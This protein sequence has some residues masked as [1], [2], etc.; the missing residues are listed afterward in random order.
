MINVLYISH[1]SADVLGSS[2]SLF[3]MITSLYGKVNPIVV[4]PQKGPAFDFF[5]QKQICT[6]IVPYP[7]DITDKHGCKRYISFLPRLLKD[8]ILYREGI[9]KIIKI[10]K[11]NNIDIIHSNSSTIDVGYYVSEKTGKPHVWHLR[12][13]QDLDFGFQPVYGWNRLIKFIKKASATICITTAIQKHFHLEGHQNSFQI[14]NAVRSSKKIPIVNEKEKYFMCCGK[15]TKAKG[16]DLAI[17]CFSEFVKTNPGYRLKLIGDISDSY[18]KELEILAKDLK[19]Y[20]YVN[21]EGYQSNTEQYF[22]KASGFLMCSK[23]EAMGRVTV[24]AMFYGCP[25]IGYDAGG[26]KEIISH[27]IDG[28]LFKN[29]DEGVY[30]MQKAIEKEYIDV[31]IK[32]ARKKAIDSFSEESYQNKIYSIYLDLM[33]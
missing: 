12:E 7:L 5:S 24:E 11:E 19:S 21:F 20:N 4:V 22:Q 30:F 2:R 3:N 28:F 1:E 25:V 17:R 15:L 8:F 18:K 13:F 31:I 6:Y 33:P 23:N 16:C 14:F 29:I 26:T 27:G 10:I 9:K 32:N